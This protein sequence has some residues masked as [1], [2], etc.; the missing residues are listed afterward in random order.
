MATNCYRS[1][2]RQAALT[3]PRY[4]LGE[5]SIGDEYAHAWYGEYIAAEQDAVRTAKTL[6]RACKAENQMPYLPLARTTK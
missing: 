2:S 1:L 6:L 4:E 5:A 3:P